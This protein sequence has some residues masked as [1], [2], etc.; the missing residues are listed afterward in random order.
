MN[1]INTTIMHATNVG[2]RTHSGFRKIAILV[3]V[4][5]VFV[6]SNAVH[7]FAQQQ[8]QRTFSSAEEAT[9]ALFLAVQSQ[10]EAALSDVLGAKSELVSTGDDLQD[11]L[12]REQFVQ[13]YQEMHRLVREPDKTTVLYV[14][15]ENRPFP[16]PLVSTN[17]VWRFDSEA[18]SNEVLCRR[19]GEN[20][21]MVIGDFRLLILA[22]QEYERRSQSSVPEYT[23]RFV[24]P[25][26][27]H[28]ALHWQGDNAI[29]VELARAGIDDHVPTDSAVPFHGYYFRILT[30]QGKHAPGGAKSYISDGKMT[31]GFAF[32][33][34]PAQYRSSGV[35]TFIAGSDG[36]VYEK[37]LGPETATIA[38]SMTE[39][40]ADSSWRPAE[41]YQG[42]L[43]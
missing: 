34:Y 5:T 11:K 7:G 20:E 10:D 42:E 16:I 1:C 41:Q 37:D 36:N 25:N 12:E 4:L 32:V 26:G 39:Y 23:T 38:S 14:G 22:Q 40:E 28:K 24:D 2:A 8:P 30:A 43:Q 27:T 29:P 31:S 21:S 15:A 9:R 17:G 33:A 13:K 6:I 18:G 35:K 19:I 3:L